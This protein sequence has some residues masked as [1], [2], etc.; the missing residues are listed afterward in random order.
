[1]LRKEIFSKV[2]L[3]FLQFF[4]GL[5]IARFLGA[6]KNGIFSLFIT[7]VSLF[8][9]IIGLSFDSA[10]I[11]FLTKK[12][13]TLPEINHLILKLSGIQVLIFLGAFF[14][15]SYFTPINF[16]ERSF[17]VYE[18]FLVFLFVFSSIII[19]SV[20]AIFYANNSIFMYNFYLVGFYIVFI[21][22]IYFKFYFAS[23]SKPFVNSVLYFYTF[24]IFLQAILSFLLLV[25]FFRKNE[26]G[27]IKSTVFSKEI[28][29]YGLIVFTGNLI[30]FL[31]YRMDFWFIDFYGS[32]KDVGL[33]SLAS[34]IAQLW[35]VLPQICAAVF[36][37]LI[38]L[39]NIS[40]L[41]FKKVLVKI[42]LLSVITGIVAKFIYPYFIIFFVGKEF[43]ESFLPFILLLPGV[44][45]F[46]VN[47]LLSAKYSGEG[48]VLINFK[49]SLFCFIVILIFNVL[50][51]PKFGINGAA[52]ASSIAYISSTVYAL[53]QYKYVNPI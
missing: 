2:L 12:K 36:F 48:G 31:C 51:I 8:I 24:F 11:Y 3:Q 45:F 50:L 53:K 17:F 44:I 19:N 27:F 7:E 28:I 43:S 29:K 32:K 20:T 1:M 4:V 23:V 14:I 47:I 16:L 9:L 33:Y 52:I 10:I 37:P 13:L 5:L 26:S 6:E 22:V 15:L 35:W 21:T 18:A 46:S 30:Q 41:F 34:K 39:G 25:Y 40:D 42:L 49:S 38:S